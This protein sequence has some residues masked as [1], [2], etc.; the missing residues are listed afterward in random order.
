MDVR[1]GKID[2]PTSQRIAVCCS[3]LQCVA[4]RCSECV[5]WMCASERLTFLQVSVLQ[6]VAV[7]CSVLQCDAVSVLCMD[8]RV[9]KLDV[10][11]SQ[12]CGD[13]TRQLS[14]IFSVLHCV[15]LCCSECVAVC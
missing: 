8:V 13:C 15:A 2:V 4:V 10:P 9:G 3:V 11:T 5:V 12:P 1:V 7:C 14:W 6:C